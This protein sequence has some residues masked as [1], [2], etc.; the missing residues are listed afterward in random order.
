MSTTLAL[1]DDL[2][3]TLGQLSDSLGGASGVN[4]E[5][6]SLDHIKV[7]ATDDDPTIQ[8]RPG[9]EVPLT[10]KG[11][12]VLADR[13][14]VPV[15]FFKRL[16]DM[17]GIAEQ[18]SLITTLLNYTKE[19]SVTAEYAE[20]G[21]LLDLYAPNALRI[22]PR[23]VASTLI[24]VLG[25]PDSP[26]QRVINTPTE[27]AV[28]VHVPID[29][30]RGIGGDPGGEAIPEALRSYS[31]TTNSTVTDLSRVGDI[32][33]GGVRIA[34]DRKRNL[35]PSV[36]GWMFRLA[37]TN[38]METPSELT[39]IDARGMTIDEVM[40][41][42]ELKA[43]LAFEQVE[44]EIAHFY[45]MRNVEVANPERRLRAVARERRIPDR[46]LMRMLDAAP[47]ALGSTTTEFDIA[48]L[49]S[50]F[51]NHAST[52]NDGGRL[53]LERAAGGT[54]IDHSL[55]CGSCNHVLMD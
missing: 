32:T 38:G 49:V 10:G 19:S 39:K 27:F 14:Q 47:E 31:W 17:G 37:C 5:A 30:E 54:V 48:C 4:T 3:L 9:L 41:D 42:L 28:D 13:L 36:Q 23:Q 20:D 12:D 29:S 53:L 7:N 1:R 40:M 24:S 50:N 44:N 33:A 34:L 45:D 6:L 18:G 21:G 25:S 35:A 15:P 46:S 51:A 22:S 11:L 43:R 16:G 8:L 55:R 52:R 2:D 26:V